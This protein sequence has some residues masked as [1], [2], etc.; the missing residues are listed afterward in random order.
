MERARERERERGR[1][2][3]GV[4]E[5]KTVSGQ[6]LQLLMV[7]HAEFRKG[8]RSLDTKFMYAL[9]SAAV[10]RRIHGNRCAIARW[11]PRTAQVMI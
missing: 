1:T 3:D 10:I 2:R 9:V 4:R 11:F 7:V 5:R 6:L 8:L